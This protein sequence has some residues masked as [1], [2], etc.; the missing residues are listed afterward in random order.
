[1]I[2]I[3]PLVILLHRSEQGPTN[4]CWPHRESKLSFIL[5]FYSGMDHT[6]SSYNDHNKRF[7]SLSIRTLSVMSRSS[8][9]AEAETR[10]ESPTY[11]REKNT[12]HIHAKSNVT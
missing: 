1:V 12:P 8:E 11:I 2:L 3:D 6:I 10:R 5:S 7:L 9:Y 4:Y